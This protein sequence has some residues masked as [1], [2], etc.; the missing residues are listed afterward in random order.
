MSSLILVLEIQTCQYVF[1][2]WIDNLDTI[3]CKIWCQ[4][5]EAS[6][7]VFSLGTFGGVSLML[8]FLS[9][10]LNHSGGQALSNL[11]MWMAKFSP[12]LHKIGKTWLCSNTLTCSL[13]RALDSC[14]GWKIPTFWV[15]K[16]KCLTSIA[17]YSGP[18][19]LC[20]HWWLTKIIFSEFSWQNCKKLI[21]FGDCQI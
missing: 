12:T 3:I 7:S 16:C 9:L 11:M 1:S 17:G 10:S 21:V 6:E 2:L 5:I 8:G 20:F 14:K 15:L 19:H 18:V 13:L 4:L